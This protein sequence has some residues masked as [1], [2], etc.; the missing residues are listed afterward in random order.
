MLRA[1]QDNQRLKRERVEM[2]KIGKVITFIK[3]AYVWFVDAVYD[4]PHVAAC[5]LIILLVAEVV[6]LFVR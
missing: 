6:G 1:F 2:E 3:D 5:A 4:H